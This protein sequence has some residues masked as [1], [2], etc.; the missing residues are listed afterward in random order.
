MGTELEE[1]LVVMGRQIL[2][3][4]GVDAVTI[5]EVARRCG[6][7]HGAPRRYFPSRAVLLATI[8]R[9]C[10][11]ELHGRLTIT[12]GGLRDTASAYVDFAVERPHAFDLIT[13]H[14]LLA[15]SGRD[16]RATSLPL[17]DEWRSRYLQ[18]VPEAGPVEA[19][20]AWAAVHG[21]AVLA[22]RRA[23]EVVDVPP[24]ALLAELVPQD[25][26]TRG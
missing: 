4:D 26:P 18:A 12:G 21:V 1:R 19:T 7:S 5:R 25:R 11:R 23:L 8:A 15:E 17:L 2:D 24:G 20:A 9:D 22:S 3:T 6:V 14:D 13:R 16:L 10:L